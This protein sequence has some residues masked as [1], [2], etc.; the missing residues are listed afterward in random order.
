MV[1]IGRTLMADPKMLLVDEP[2]A[3]LSKMLAQE[4]FEMLTHLTTRDKL[5]ILL[6]DQEIR[7]ALKIADA[8]CKDS[9]AASSTQ[10]SLLVDIFNEYLYFFEAGCEEMKPCIAAL[11]DVITEHSKTANDQNDAAIVYFQSTCACMK[12][13]PALA[14]AVA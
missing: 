1:E 4:V 12:A 2:T 5:T 7:Q 6:V 8:W 3:G 10:L 14:D 11:R 9:T 13:N